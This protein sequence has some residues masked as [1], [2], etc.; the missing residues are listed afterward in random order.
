[1]RLSGIDTDVRETQKMIREVND[2]EKS[3]NE[4]V[5]LWNKSLC[6]THHFL[7]EKE[8]SEIGL[9]VQDLIIS[10]VYLI[11]AENVY[12]QIAGFMG[13]QGR[14]IEMLFFWLRKEEKGLE[15]V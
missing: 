15:V 14:K 4:L 10:V 7:S 3:L 6:A 9:Y 2:R 8:I 1:M 12:H 13:I 5:E 11:I